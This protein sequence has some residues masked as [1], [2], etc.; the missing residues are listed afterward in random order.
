[1]KL[2]AYGVCI[3]GLTLLG[4][5]NPCV[6][7]LPPGQRTG[8]LFLSNQHGRSAAKLIVTFASR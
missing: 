4:A 1:M 2:F 3:F 7:G 5:D 8:P 6:S